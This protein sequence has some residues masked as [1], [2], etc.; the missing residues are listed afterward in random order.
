[1]STALAHDV[2]NPAGTP[3]I[4]LL[5]S[6][7]LD[8]SIWDDVVSLL[9]ATAAVVTLD[10]PGHGVS[11]AGDPASVESMA[12]AV[13]GLLRHLDRGPVVLVGM[14]LGG[15]V[16]QALAIRHPHAV[17]ALGLIDT[18]AWYG[19]EAPASWATRADRAMRQGL[20]S[21][22][23]FQLDL[24]FTE[25]FR[26]DRPGVGEHLLAIFRRNRVD[27]YASACRALG[28]MDLRPGL[29]RISAPT[30]I[31]VGDLDGATPP[32]HAQALRRAISGSVLTVIP[33]C[34]HLSALERPRE[35]VAGLEPILGSAAPAS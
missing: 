31:V 30:A 18:T 6:L 27:H 5:H 19:E 28:A 15:S 22:A 33:R 16:A 4:A 9:P 7:A 2:H 26:A 20:A 11:P 34:G 29:A 14:S 13:A 17:S 24:W 12:D 21:L 1:M 23:A 3:T 35:V 8:R 32:A 10:L 25:E